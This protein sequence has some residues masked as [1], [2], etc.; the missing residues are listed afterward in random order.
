M[1]GLDSRLGAQLGPHPSVEVDLARPA[2][3]ADVE[4]KIV[5]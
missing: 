4:G 2:I 3:Q 5:G 1:F